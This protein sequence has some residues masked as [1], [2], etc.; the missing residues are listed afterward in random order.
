MAMKMV[1]DL[2]NFLDVPRLNVFAETVTLTFAN[3][4]KTRFVRGTIDV[5]NSLSNYSG[6]CFDEATTAIKF[7][8]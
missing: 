5:K 6:M 1:M 7:S 4:D 2:D 8:V 3:K